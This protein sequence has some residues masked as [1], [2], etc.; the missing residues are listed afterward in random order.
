MNSRERVNTTLNHK[1]P[2][3][4][5]LDLGGNVSGIHIRAYK[6]LIEYLGIEDKN[7]RYHDFVQQLA[8]PC[9]KLLEKL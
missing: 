4:I 2:D 1:E 3:K 6:R 9:E 8:V 7:I 5:P